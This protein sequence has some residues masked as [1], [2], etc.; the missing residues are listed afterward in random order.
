MAGW[1][2]KGSA[3]THKSENFIV[4]WSYST[5]LALRYDAVHYDGMWIFHTDLERKSAPQEAVDD[6]QNLVIR[7]T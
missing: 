2:G 6:Q 5:E 7:P 3:D 1:E 4:A